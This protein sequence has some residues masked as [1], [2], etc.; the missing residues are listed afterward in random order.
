MDSD[1]K[2]Y[3]KR[4]VTREE[5]D[6]ACE[7]VWTEIEYQNNLPKRTPDEAKDIPGFLTLLRRYIRKIEEVWSDNPAVEQPDGTW[8]VVDAEHG[9]R[10]LAGIA[11]RAMIYNHIRRR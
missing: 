6:A 8:T 5:F 10:K 2:L 3:E 7:A 9:L 4:T 1:R 11:I